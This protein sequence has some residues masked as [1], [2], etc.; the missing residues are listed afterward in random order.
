MMLSLVK[1]EIKLC[2][3][4]TRIQILFITVF[5]LTLVVSILSSYEYK[6]KYEKYLAESNT[7]LNN[8]KKNFVYATITPKLLKRP[9]ELSIIS[10][11]I[12]DDMGDCVDFD[13]LNIPFESYKINRTNDYTSEFANL[14]ISKVL[15]WL[16]SLIALFIS[17]DL[18]SREN[19]LG[20]LKLSL[21][22]KISRNDIFLSKLIAS[23]LLMFFLIILIL[24][25]VTLLYML[26]PWLYLN[27]DI[28]CRILLLFITLFLFSLF[29]IASGI[30]FSTISKSSVQ[31]LVFCLSFWV[32]FTIVIPSLIKSAIG[33][34]NFTSEN[35]KVHASQN[36]VMKQYWAKNNEAWTNYLNPLINDLK[37]GTFGGSPGW[38]PIWGANPATKEACIKYYSLLNPLKEKIAKNKYEIANNELILHLKKKLRTLT[39]L[40]CLSPV[41]STDIILMN[42]S[43]T[44][45]NDY[46]K[47]LNDVRG[48]REVVLKYVQNKNGFSSSKWFTPEPDYYP[49]NPNHPLCPSD[50]YKPSKDELAKLSNYYQDAKKNSN[51]ML[52]I[53]DFPQFKITFRNYSDLFLDIWQYFVVI[54]LSTIILLVLGFKLMNKYN[55][56]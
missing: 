27:F 7:S 23:C 1:K 22:N 4:E 2:L 34:T 43:N 11:G 9:S 29:F 13:Y 50:V 33:N 28:F 24:L 32:M 39:L 55:L 30:F 52:D 41:T 10:K 31:S 49:F 18:V 20:T 17:Y 3:L 21:V 40:S 15:I 46:F 45:Y 25:I 14:D 37:F 44:S 36:E 5:S 12:E 16:I 8:L 6:E 56:N 19:E 54:C 47:F 48:Y 53:T 26:S 42:V 38:E 51:F 35:S